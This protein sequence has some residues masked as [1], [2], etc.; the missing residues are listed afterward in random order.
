M[1]SSFCLIYWINGKQVEKVEGD[2]HACIHVS[3]ITFIA[4]YELMGWFGY[5]LSFCEDVDIG[6]F[7]DLFVWID[8]RAGGVSVYLH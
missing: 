2:M 3:Y 7:F 5:L 1:P 4:I 6:S 8:D